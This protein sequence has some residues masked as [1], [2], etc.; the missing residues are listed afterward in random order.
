[1]LRPN[2]LWGLAS[3]LMILLAACSAPGPNPQA[4]ATA[5]RPSEPRTIS[6]VQ[7]GVNNTLAGEDAPLETP[8]SGVVAAES[9]EAET[10]LTPAPT[11]STMAGQG[12]TDEQLRLLA[13]LD[14]LGAAPELIHNEIWL[15]SEP[16]TLAELR[17]K[18]VMIEF[19]TFG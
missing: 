9:T 18:V 13:G 5:V 12:P 7:G 19:W 16:L 1:M 4:R 17:G 6:I 3:G 15:N 10:S 11:A 8:T 2:R 14:D